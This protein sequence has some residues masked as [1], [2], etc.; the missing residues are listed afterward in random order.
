[1]SRRVFFSFHYRSDAWR[2]SQVRNMGIVEG[3]RPVSDNVWEA[4]K[5]GGDKAIK[6]WISEQLKGKSCSV[7][8]VG[9]K[10]AGR[11][12]I[13]HEVKESWQSGKGIVGICIHNLKNSLG[14]KS[15]KGRNPFEDFL[16]GGKKLSSIA[17]LHN[18]PYQ[19][20]ANVYDYIKKNIG[21]WVEE[22]IKMRN[23]Y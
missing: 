1:M 6:K 18:P 4:V 13:K 20:S 8:L 2:A 14:E 19:N 5:R 23:Q 7:V 11:K 9:E 10:T 3:N 16:V 21:K 15:K 12:W 17:K 22:A